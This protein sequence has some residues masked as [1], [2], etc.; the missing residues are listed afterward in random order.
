M[1]WQR[2]RRGKRDRVQMIRNAIGLLLIVLALLGPSRAAWA[3][4]VE[5][6]PGV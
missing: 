4:T 5:V 6:A 1:F 3:Q 2:A